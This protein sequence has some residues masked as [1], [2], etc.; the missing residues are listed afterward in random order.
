MSGIF[1]FDLRGAHL[2]DKIYDALLAN[3]GGDTA[4]ALEKARE[5]FVR[6]RQANGPLPRPNVD[7]DTLR[8]ALDATLD[9]AA[10]DPPNLD[11]RRNAKVAAASYRAGSEEIAKWQG[12]QIFNAFAIE[13]SKV[14]LAVAV[15]A[16]AGTFEDL[17]AFRIA[18]LVADQKRR[19]S[20]YV[21]TRAIDRGSIAD[22]DANRDELEAASAAYR[23]AMDNYRV[24]IDTLCGIEGPIE[25]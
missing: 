2:S 7:F 16:D 11:A 23:V 25:A 17:R 19:Q 13:T 5:D 8:K 15:A 20:V 18:I 10:D 12:A 21:S 4:M 24:A 9:V 6:Q 3:S 1:D 14:V 22:M